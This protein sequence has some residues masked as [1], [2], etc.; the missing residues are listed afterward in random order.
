M[1]QKIFPKCTSY[2]M[3]V[4]VCFYLLFMLKFC[5]HTVLPFGTINVIKI[6]SGRKYSLNCEIIAMALKLPNSPH[7]R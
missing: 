4:S 2:R 5:I 7:A 3:K 1:I 6:I